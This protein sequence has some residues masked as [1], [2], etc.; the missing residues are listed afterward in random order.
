LERITIGKIARNIARVADRNIRALFPQLHVVPVIFESMGEQARST[1]FAA[2]H[3]SEQH[4]VLPRLGENPGLF[5]KRDA[6]LVRGGSVE[7]CAC[8]K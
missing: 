6:G 8:F 7:K 4:G 5:Y 1:I 2:R 3:D